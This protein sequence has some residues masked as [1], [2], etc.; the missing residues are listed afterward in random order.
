VSL[1]DAG[2]HD[3]QVFLRLNVSRYWVV[4]SRFVLVWRFVGLSGVV[5]AHLL[6]KA[7]I[8]AENGVIA[9]LLSGF[10]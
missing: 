10:E 7:G 1:A 4:F 5:T 6:E 2:K 9:L 3:R 8:L